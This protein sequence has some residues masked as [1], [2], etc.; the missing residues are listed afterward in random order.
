MAKKDEL[1]DKLPP[2]NI[3]AEKSL[4]GGL[5]MDKEAIYKIIDFFQVK[6]FYET[7]HRDIYQAMVDIVDESG[8]IDLLSVANRLEEKELLEKIGGNSYLTEL[9]NSVPTA[10][11]VGEYAKIIQKKRILR[12][13]IQA[14]QEISIAG[15]N[16]DKNVE[17]VLDE[18]EQKIFS[19][20]APREFYKAG[21]EALRRAK[22]K[23]P[24][25]AKI[26]LDKGE[27]MISS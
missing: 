17:E 23:L 24:L 9:V 25:N 6:D 12:E 20:K 13:M 27:E 2:R 11:H 26:S 16:E 3:D 1:P 18:A 10:S 19:I 4:L 15:Y 5:M 21:R 14:G 22:M 7:D 8:S